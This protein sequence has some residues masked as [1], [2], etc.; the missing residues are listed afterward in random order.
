[1]HSIT[2]SGRQPSAIRWKRLESIYNVY[3]VVRLYCQWIPRGNANIVSILP[4]ENILG[5]DSNQHAENHRS[6]SGRN[7][8]HTGSSHAGI[9][10][11]K[12]G[13]MFTVHPHGPE[14]RG[15]LPTY[16]DKLRIQ[17]Y[18]GNPLYFCESQNSYC[19]AHVRESDETFPK[20][21]RTLSNSS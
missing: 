9:N 21:Q 3:R 6:W 1:M 20:H 14:T 10:F 16:P 18:K 11:D 19:S 4:V 2:F 8:F 13:N 15:M 5:S 7:F 12:L 17:L